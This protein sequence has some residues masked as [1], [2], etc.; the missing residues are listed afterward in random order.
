MEK[1]NDMDS[2]DTRKRDVCPESP[3]DKFHGP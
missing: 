1:I 2:I 3:R